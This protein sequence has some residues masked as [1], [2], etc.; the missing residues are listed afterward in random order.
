MNDKKKQ[1]GIRF[2]DVIVTKLNFTRVPDIYQKPELDIKFSNINYLNAEKTECTT[3]LTALINEK[4]GKFNIEATVAGIFEVKNGSENM[5][6][7]EFIENNAM[8]M[9]FPYLREIIADITRRAGIK[10]ILLPPINIKAILDM[11][12]AEQE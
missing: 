10:T 5:G 12:R 2:K 11:Q 7:E 8:I 9:L 4:S 6:L 1:P 3:E